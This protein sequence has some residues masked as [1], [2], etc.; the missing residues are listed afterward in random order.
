MRCWYMQIL[1]H[2]GNQ[3]QWKNVYSIMPIRCGNTK[4]KDYKKAVN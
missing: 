4:H 2:E 1:M 3:T